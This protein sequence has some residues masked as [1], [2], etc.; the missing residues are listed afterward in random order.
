MTTEHPPA[1]TPPA[2]TLPPAGR[3]P[4][5]PPR[6]EPDTK[7]WTW[8][9]ERPCPDCGYRAMDVAPEQVGALAAE[10]TAGWAEVLRGPE[11]ATRP[12]PTVWSPLE[13]ACHV[14]D[15][16]RVFTG[17]VALMLEQ[18]DPAFANWDQDQTAVDEAYHA[19][20]PGA[21]AAELA[22]AAELVCRAFNEVRDAQ[23][24]RTGHRSD[25]SLFTVATL[26]QYFLHDLVHHL[27]DVGRLEVTGD[28]P[29]QTG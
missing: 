5:S 11:A 22:T 14:R 28:A 18:E 29:A 27:H 23:W 10:A 3:A 7:D 1:D 20:D 6:P 24:Q 21:V 25:G 26:G 16:C 19:Q 15:V 17:R 8:T 9:L 4:A 12:A 13:Y 2:D